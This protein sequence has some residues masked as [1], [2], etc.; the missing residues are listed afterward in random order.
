MNEKRLK[1]ADMV[2]NF[3]AFWQAFQAVL[4]ALG[5]NEKLCCP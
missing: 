5:T 2:C 4:I 3:L 1:A